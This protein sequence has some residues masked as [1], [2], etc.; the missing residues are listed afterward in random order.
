[1]FCSVC[2]PAPRGSRRPVS[3][4]RCLM[5]ELTTLAP[6]RYCLKQGVEA[7]LVHPPRKGAGLTSK[8]LRTDGSDIEESAQRCRRRTYP[9]RGTAR[10][11]GKRPASTSHSLL[12]RRLQPVGPL[13]RHL[14]G[15]TPRSIP[16][17]SH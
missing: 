1:M 12:D 7:L 11:Y 16:C 3:G 4:T 8:T 5:A 15:V 14:A 13:G 9:L 10:I 6:P 17:N 2:G